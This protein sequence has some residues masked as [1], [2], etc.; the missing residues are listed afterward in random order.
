MEQSFSFEFLLIT[1]LLVALTLGIFYIYYDK[2]RGRS[3][4]DKSYLEGLKYMAEGEN[5]RAVEKFKEAVRNDSSNIDAYIKIGIIL[6]SE[7]L[8]NNAVR[9]HKDLTLRGDLS[10]D[11]LLEV[12]KNIALDYWEGGRLENA[13]VYFNE[14][15]SNKLLLTWVRPYLLKIYESRKEWAKAIDLS[16]ESKMGTTPH[17]KARLAALKVKYGREV[18]K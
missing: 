10:E 12:K 4:E 13:E 7:G 9:I 14:L 3:K 17:G 6:R 2:K 8:I 16:M 11:E 1:L 15:K 5:R 18:H